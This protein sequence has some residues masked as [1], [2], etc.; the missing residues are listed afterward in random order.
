MNVQKMSDS[1][2]PE[3]S[4][5]DTTI[6]ASDD[7]N[8]SQACIDESFHSSNSDLSGHSQLY[9]A[10]CFENNKQPYNTLDIN[11]TIDKIG[12]LRIPIVGYEVMEE[13]A[14][15]TVYKLRIEHK[16]GG[17]WFIFRR[18]TDFVRLL[19]QL[20]RQK[21]PISHLSLPG[22]KW[23]GDNFAPSFLED[24]IR[25]LQKFVD[26]ILSTPTLIENT[27]VREFFCLDEPPALSD[28]ADEARAIVESL[29]DN[30]YHLKQQLYDRE[31][32]LAAANSVCNELRTK[33]HQIIERR[34]CPR[35]GEF[36]D[37]SE[38]YQ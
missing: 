28:T 15:F 26:A 35:C 6:A 5:N 20:R 30:I 18:Y 1:T 37:F 33:L 32:A 22:K 9:N 8:R 27:S 17:S 21:L 4:T 31:I 23:I 7:E 14:R 12:D 36:I 38:I 24:R 2:T 34:V 25:R 19:T 16:D 3:Q 10:Q 13:R 29:E 11:S